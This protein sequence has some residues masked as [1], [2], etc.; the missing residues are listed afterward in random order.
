MNRF[1]SDCLL[2]SELESWNIQEN[3]KDPRDKFSVPENCFN[4]VISKSFTEMQGIQSEPGTFACPGCRKHY[5][6]KRNMLSHFRLEC[7]KIPQLQ[8]HYCSY[9][10]KK[11]Y[12]LKRHIKN[13]HEGRFQP[14]NY[15]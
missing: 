10:S 13:R 15:I 12:D 6:Y 5:R 8:C 3:W 7:G 1:Y 2:I 11:K 9:R 14:L 4:I